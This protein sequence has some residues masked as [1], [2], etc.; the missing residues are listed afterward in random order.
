VILDGTGAP[1]SMDPVPAEPDR[2]Y[3]R[4]PL[5]IE[6]VPLPPGYSRDLLSPV[7]KERLR[8]EHLDRIGEVMAERA[9]IAK[10]CE[11]D[12]LYREKVLVICER[13]P[14]WWGDRFCWTY[15]DRLGTD[16]PFVHY[17]FQVEKFVEPYKEM[18]TTKGRTR[19]TRVGTKSRGVGATW[20][21]LLL[22]TH[23]FLFKENWSVLLGAVLRDDV[24]DGGQAATH[25]SLFGKIRYL[26]A[27]LPRWMRD[28]LLGPL[29]QREDFNK[30]NLLKNPSK[31]RNI[32][33]GRQF[34]GMFGRGHRYSE[35]LGDEIAHAEEMEAAD[36][37]LK[38]TTNRFE[39]FSTPKGK[40][41][42]HYQTFSG[43]IPGARTYYVHWSEHPEND[44]DWYNEQRDHMTDEAIAQELDCSFEASAGGRVLKEV[45]L[46]KWFSIPP[47]REYEP[48]LPLH[49]IIDPGIA[50]ATAVTWGQWDVGRAE[51]RVL[52]FVHAEG[53][54]I[55]WL[56]PFVLGFVPKETHRGIPWP[57]DY[58]F[59]ELEIIERH[60]RWKAPETV[61]GDEYGKARS[62]VT[63]LSAY[64]ELAQYAIFVCTVKIE[65]D[66]AA[67]AKLELFIRYVRFAR[68]L[69]EQ[70]NGPPETCPSMGE[71]VTQWRYP[72][73]KVGD[74]RPI[75]KPVHDKYCH[76][77]DTLKM[78]AW[79]LDL[80]D[81]TQ[82][83][84][85]S[86]RVK[87]AR[88]SDLRGGKDRWPR[89]RRR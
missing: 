25:E 56:V 26:I 27:H 82:Q 40:H 50:D 22:R 43:V 52:D 54:T 21:A 38:Q 64:D 30:R 89:Y 87:K 76:G 13:D 81:A 18:L 88:G 11:D 10:R 77:G 44:L 32:I 58:S 23:S 75:T 16:E 69:A 49:V 17:P 78:W 42:F 63:G 73:R 47:D 51:G 3:H 7:R 39:G 14:Q 65:D 5:S 70:R 48:G 12:V 8:L 67:L 28:R 71:V 9:F 34:S 72:T 60:A 79:M 62:L 20:D 59:A 1:A 55:D 35:A 46:E 85:A 6:E 31:P 33:V 45:L 61:Y 80:P 68:R 74:Y 29:F 15:D 2:R 37:S 53:K 86:G 24:D 4:R 19:W 36:T 66:L 41:T 57:H 84:V 83:P